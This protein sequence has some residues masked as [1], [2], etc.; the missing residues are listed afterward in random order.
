MLKRI[1][2]AALAALM[3]LPTPSLA[4]E[5]QAESCLRERV[6]DGY[7]DG[8]GIRTMTST[9]LET[10]KTRNYLVTLYKG[11]Q[12]RIE[13]CGD[14]KVANVDVLLYDADGNVLVR[15]ETADASPRVEFEPSKTGSYYVV[16][17]QRELTGAEKAGVA[18]A[19][20]YR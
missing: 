11:N 15:D 8:W 6:W 19:V 18:M 12:Y 10:G 14:D 20:V 7:A 13:A 16:V 5:E 17:Y 9:T 1:P 3:L 4:G 2:V